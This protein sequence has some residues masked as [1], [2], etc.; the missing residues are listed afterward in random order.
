VYLDPNGVVNAASFAPFTAG[1]SP[2]EF[3]VLYGS[4]F[5]TQNAVASSLPLQ[6][7]LN[8][9]QVMINGTP[10]PL[11]YVT[12]TQLAA[13]VPFGVTYT[14]PTGSQ[15]I[16]TIQV[17]TANGSSNSV[18][19]FV[20]LTTP[21]IFSLTANGVGYGAIEHA[22]TGRVVNASSPAQPGEIVS[23]FV[24]GLGTTLPA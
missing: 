12:P 1:I 21:G 4:G 10:A 20:N 5:S 13:V 7:T 14:A 18:S 16:A 17:V 19:E 23:V 24:S 22:L 2:G 9:V 3:I 15:Q 6:T 11:F 8:N